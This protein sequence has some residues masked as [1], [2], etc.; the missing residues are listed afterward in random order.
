MS[1]STIKKCNCTHDF[2]DKE[3]GNKNRVF[4]LSENEEKA[5]CTVCDTVIILNKSKK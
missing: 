3:H 1:R 4:N 2:Q 5:K